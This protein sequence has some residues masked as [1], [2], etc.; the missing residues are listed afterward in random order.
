MWREWRADGH[1]FDADDRWRFKR[2]RCGH[3]KPLLIKLG[4]KY[5]VSVENKTGQHSFER[6]ARGSPQISRIA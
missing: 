4:G 1:I 2:R 5:L 6:V 3:L